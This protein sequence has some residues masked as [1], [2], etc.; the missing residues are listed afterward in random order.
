MKNREDKKEGMTFEAVAAIIFYA[1]NESYDH[2]SSI[3][4]DEEADEGMKQPL[5]HHNKP[6]CYATVHHIDKGQYTAGRPISSAFLDAMS[7]ITLPKADAKSFF[8]HNRA[9]YYSHRT[10]QLVWWRPAGPQHVLFAESTRIQSGIAKLP[11]LLFCY[12]GSSLEV[13]AL[14]DDIRPTPDTLLY[15]GPF[16]N[17]GCM[18]NVRM[19]FNV[20][21]SDCERIED[22]FFSS[23]FTLNVKPMLDRLDPIDLWTNLTAKGIDFPIDCLVPHRTLIEHITGGERIG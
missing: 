11:P 1:F 23:E 21:P 22:L 15:K 17:A 9:V 20:Y 2:F 10:R 14:K 3:V 13:F 19:P 8:L 16:F 6:L 12:F 5:L 7:S 18:G 4:G